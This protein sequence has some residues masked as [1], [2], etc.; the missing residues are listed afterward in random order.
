[1]LVGGSAPP[2]PD[3][4]DIWIE[5]EEKKALEKILTDADHRSGK[6]LLVLIPGARWQS[7]RWPA[8]RFRELAVKLHQS[9]PVTIV[10]AGGKSD[11]AI[12]DEI[13]TDAPFI[14]NLI[15]KT[16]LKMLASLLKSA[17]VVVTNDTGP[18][19]IAA[20]VKTPVVGLFGPT[21]P[22]IVGPYGEIH[23][24]LRGDC[25]RIPCNQEPYRL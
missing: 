1:M 15:G 8:T 14:I 2:R 20:A 5:D 3:A 21:D 12:G 4:H 24:V 7:K 6:D 11:T 10:I 9:F 17:T 22:G 19:H 25:D 16:T 23:T 18:M 13:T